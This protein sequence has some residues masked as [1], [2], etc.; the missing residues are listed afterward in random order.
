MGDLRVKRFR[1][2]ML[3]LLGAGAYLGDVRHPV[4][5]AM[6]TLDPGWADPRAG[7]SAIVDA[8][9]SGLGRLEMIEGAGHHPHDQYPDQVVSLIRAFL[10]PDAVRA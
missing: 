6:G 8:P 2:G 7:G 3:R 4:L 10:R 5:V 9:P 1:Q